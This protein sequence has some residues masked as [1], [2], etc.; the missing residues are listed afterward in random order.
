MADITK[1]EGTDCPIRDVCYRYTATDGIMQS[2]FAEVPMFKFK[3]GSMGCNEYL[4]K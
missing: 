3:D 1:C 2:Y 4:E